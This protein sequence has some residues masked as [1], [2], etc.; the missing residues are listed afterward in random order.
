MQ[1]ISAKDFYA[2]VQRDL[3]EPLGLKQTNGSLTTPDDTET[4]DFAKAS[5]IVLS[6]VKD[7]GK[8]V[9]QNEIQADQLADKVLAEGKLQSL[10]ESIGLLTNL[11][12]L[13]LSDNQLTSLPDSIGGL[14]QLEAGG[15]P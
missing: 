2:S 6:S 7:H 13:Y 4:I 3:I 9:Y 15:F 1:P 8:A 12:W 11:E 14:T 5:S 10:P